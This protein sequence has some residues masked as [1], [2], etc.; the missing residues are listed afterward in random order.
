VAIAAAQWRA[1]GDEHGI[2]IADA[3]GLH[4][5]FEPAL[6]DV[7]GNKINEAGL[8]DRD[9]SPSQRRDPTGI[10]VDASHMMT[11]IGKAG[12]GNQADIPGADHG[13]AHQGLRFCSRIGPTW[14]RGGAFERVDRRRRRA[15]RAL[16]HQ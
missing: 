3:A 1:D 8:E 2:G 12:A 11:E 14:R 10:L 15:L 4:G 16:A 6:L 7:R 9:F 13:H 5:E